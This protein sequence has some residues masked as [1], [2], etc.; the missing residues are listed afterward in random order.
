[1]TTEWTVDIATGYRKHN[2]YR[3]RLQDSTV[4]IATGYR[5]AQWILRLTTG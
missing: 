4:D 2:G 3:D 1:M 5:I